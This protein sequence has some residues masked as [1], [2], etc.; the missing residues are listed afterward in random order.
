MSAK[1]GPYQIVDFPAERRDVLDFIDLSSWQHRMYGLLEVDVT[2]VRRCL[3]AHKARTGE[4][5]SFTGY[6]AFC[7]G[8]AV[9]EHKAVQAYRQGRNQL[10]LFDDVD[11][12]MM[13]EH[14]TGAARTL[15]GYVIRRANDKT[16]LEIHRE[17]RAV[18]TASKPPDEGAPAWLPLLR[19]LPGPATKLI[20]V[21]VRQAIRRNPADRWVAMAGTV[22]ISAVGMFGKSGGWGLAAPAMH[23]TCL[24]VGGIARKPACVQERIEPRDLLSLTAAF[25]HGVVD[26]APAARF[27]ARLVELIESGCGLDAAELMAAGRQQPEPANRS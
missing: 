18:Q 1:I 12:G 22:G 8:Q 7:L 19:R 17:I 15:S 4:S 21:F 11:V 5:L 16:F 24:Y 26:G 14:G 20:N 25:D 9:N 23:T 3:A 13:I 2:V 6:L 10:A 27:T